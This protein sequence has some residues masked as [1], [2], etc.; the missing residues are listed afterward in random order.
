MAGAIRRHRRFTWV[1]VLVVLGLIALAGGFAAGNTRAQAPEGENTAVASEEGTPLAL[2]TE[3]APPTPTPNAGV[4]PADLTPT[5][6]LSDK[7]KIARPFGLVDAEPYRVFTGDGECL[8]VRYVPGTLFENDPRACVSEGFLLWM[9]GPEKVVDGQGWRYALGE[10]WVASQYVQSAPDAVRGVSPFNSVTVGQYAD[11]GTAIARIDRDGGVTEYGS[12]SG[13]PDGMSTRAA[14]A[15]RDGKWSAYTDQSGPLRLVIV[16]L[17]SG[18]EQV[19]P[20]HTALGWSADGKL[21]VTVSRNC[22][23]CTTSLGWVEPSNGVVNELP[24][25]GNLWPVWAPDGQSVV[26][27]PDGM[28]IVQIF[29]DGTRR[30]IDVQLGEGAYLGE[31]SVSPG[32]TRVMSS[33]TLGDVRIF[34]LATGAVTEVARASQV[35]N[36][37]KGGCGGSIG[38]LSTWLDDSTVVWHESYGVKGQNG[39]TIASLA[40]GT[41]RVI[42]FFS[43]QDVTAIGP[44][45]ISFTT[46]E[47]LDDREL[48][49]T[50]LLDVATGEARPAAFGAFATWQ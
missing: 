30:E 22:P 26:G 50:W 45:Y 24:D 34:D 18:S 43:I 8:N 28:R 13:R 37:G 6:I 1:G 40:D 29:L 3:V 41:R 39:I 14:V 15:S 10:G 19:Y 21:L 38:R 33:S 16:N 23:G 31:L 36:G 5:E 17:E 9:Y 48:T 35:V 11:F 25:S 4:R 46:W 7:A 12:I 47:W 27:T 20:M 2:P 32:G 42:P 49:V 44:G